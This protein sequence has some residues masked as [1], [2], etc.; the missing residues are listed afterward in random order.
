MRAIALVAALTAASHAGIVRP[1]QGWTGGADAELV[2]Q[3]GGEGHFGG[4]HG[5]VEAETWKAP[6][7][8]VLYATRIAATTS[9]RDAAAKLEIDTLHRTNESAWHE[10]VV[11]KAVEVT[12]SWKDSGVRGEVR[13]VLTGSGDAVI[14]AVK[15]ECLA[16]DDAAI[17]DVEACKAALATLDPAIDVNNRVE[18]KPADTPS[19][20]TNPNPGTGTGTGLTMSDGSHVPLP[21]IVV[22]QADPPADKRPVYVGLGVVLLATVFWWNRR[23]RERFEREE[24]S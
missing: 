12:Q 18:I 3:T 9:S 19:T 8:V 11:A 2:Q 13:F 5:I 1:P 7:G 20:S 24:K 6:R 23:R 16:G 22:K 17:A 21:P 15:G 4:V 14:V 10:G